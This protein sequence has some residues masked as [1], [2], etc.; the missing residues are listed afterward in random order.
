MY[1]EC[2]DYSKALGVLDILDSNEYRTLSGYIQGTREVRVQVNDPEFRDTEE[3]QTVFSAFN[4]G[5]KMLSLQLSGYCLIEG[6][7]QMY[8]MEFVHEELLLSDCTWLQ[9]VP[10]E[11]ERKLQKK[12]DEL[13]IT[14]KAR[15]STDHAGQV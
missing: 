15:T 9:E 14:Y 5:L 7:D 3:V 12:R 2:P 8:R 1:V 4:K 10:I 11:I 13:L 6:S